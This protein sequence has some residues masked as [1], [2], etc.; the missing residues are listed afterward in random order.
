MSA[1][2]EVEVA[3]VR[4]LTPLVREFT[5][6]PRTGRLPR[7]SAGSHI[8]LQ[9]PLGERLLR[10][11][12]SLTG[13]PARSDTYRIAVRLQEASRGGS[14][15]LHEH[16]AV[17]QHL[18]ITPPANLFALHSRA[19]LHIL[20]AGG[21]G[22]TPFMAYVDELT[23]RGAAFELHYAF[24]TG[25]SDAYADALRQR[26]GARFH[27]YDSDTGPAL[28]LQAVLTGRP[29]GTHVYTCGPQGLIAGVRAQAQALGWADSCVHSEAFAAPAPGVAFSVE[30]V[31]SH[32]RIKVAADQSLLEALEDAGLDIPNMCRGGV[33][34]QCATRHVGGEVEHHDSVLTAQERTH[35]LMPCVSRGCGTPLL[36]DL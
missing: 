7:F 26:L 34:G 33:C 9:L 10:N 14:R 24:R 19:S 16:I 32:Q 1:L 18:R 11:C 20:I 3:Q 4:P 27:A 21:I 22:I 25:L 30:L 31:R 28:D 36:L 13:D 23:Q 12:Y 35:L 8:Q 6:V 15:H 17:G 2:I 5:L 29:V